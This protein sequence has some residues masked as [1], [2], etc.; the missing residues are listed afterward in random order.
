MTMKKSVLWAQVIV[1]GLFCSCMNSGKMIH[2]SGK[3]MGTT[4][5]VKIFSDQKINT[6]ELNRKVDEILIQVN[7]SMSTYISDSEI[8]YF[9]HKHP[10]GDWMIVSDDFFH[11]VEHA[12]GVAKATNGIFDPTIGPLVN[13]WGFGPD[14]SRK[15]PEEKDIDKARAQVGYE[16]I[17]INSNEKKIRKL[18]P[19][20]YLD[21]SAS[22]KGFGVDKL[23]NYLDSLNF[24]NYMVEIG[25]EVKT[26][27]R[28]GD[29]NWSI[30]IE[31][32]HPEL[33]GERIHKVIPLSN[34]SMA[35][36]GDYRNF[37][38]EKGKKYS[39]EIDFRTGKPIE[40]TLASASVVDPESCMVADSWATAMMVMGPELAMR[41]STDLGMAVYLIYK[42][43]TDKA[44]LKFLTFESPEWKK[45]F[46]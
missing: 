42:L 39:H 18:S 37:F 23:A 14:G 44:N 28:K 21:L 17:E 11:V 12:L 41:T 8:S 22:A 4:Y 20:L 29:G 26:R 13:L 43:D 9:N 16:K 15:V 1:L 10:M 6:K 24:A 27:G 31:S 19:G 25:G 5:N 30:A 45:L 34:L 2:L 35:T 7:K 40:H 46:P 3:T 32:P 33:I 38:E 36:S